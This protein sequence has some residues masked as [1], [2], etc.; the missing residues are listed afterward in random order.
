MNQNSSTYSSFAVA[1]L[2]KSRRNRGVLNAVL[3]L[4]VA[5]LLF[6]TT[7]SYRQVNRLIVDSQWINHTHR[8]IQNVES[9]RY[10]MMDAELRQRAY[11]LN[12]SSRL[13]ADFTVIKTTLAVELTRQTR[14]T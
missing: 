14:D 12:G 3:R 7:T 6:I 13:L 8:V 9:T 5:V 1:L 10:G 2:K 4:A 11:L